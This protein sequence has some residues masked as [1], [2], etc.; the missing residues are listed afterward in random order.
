MTDEPT[1]LAAFRD[2]KEAEAV[3]AE[4]ADLDCDPGVVVAEAIIET[5][6][7]GTARP[8]VTSYLAG[9]NARDGMGERANGM[10][11]ADVLVIVLEQLGIGGRSL[12][13]G[14]SRSDR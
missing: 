6:S 14:I 4:I 13:P 3:Q 1:N 9:K 12:V 5:L 2:R 7:A 10:S 11:D 8:L